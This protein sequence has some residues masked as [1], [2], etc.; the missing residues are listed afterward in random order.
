MKRLLTICSVLVWVC[1]ISPASF[2]ET[3]AI[4][5]TVTDNLGNPIA[6]LTVEVEGFETE[7]EA[8]EAVT[9]ANGFYTVTGLAYGDYLVEAC[10]G[11]DTLYYV[12]ELYDNRTNF[13][14]ADAVTVEAP[15]TTSGIDF[16]LVPSGAITGTVTDELG[17][18]IEGMWVEAENYDDEDAM[19]MD[20]ETNEEGVYVITGLPPGDYRVSTD[21]SESGLSYENEY[22][23]NTTSE[24]LAG[25]VT[26]TGTQTT[27]GIDFTL[28]AGGAISG[29]VTDSEG[30]P[31]EDMVVSATPYSSDEGWN[32]ANTD[33]NGFYTITGLS[34]D[35]YRVQ[36]CSGCSDLSYADKF[37]D[38]TSDYYGATPV[39]VTVPDTTAEIDFTLALGTYVSGYVYGWDANSEEYVALEDAHLS[40]E[41]FSGGGGWS[42]DETDEEG[43][44][45]ITGLTAGEYRIRVD[46][47]PYIEQYY[48]AAI[49]WAG[50]EPLEI[51]ADIPA[52]NI[53]FELDLGGTITGTILDA[54]TNE[55]VTTGW[56]NASPTNGEPWGRGAHEIDSDGVYVISGLPAGT[57]K[58]SAS[59]EGYDEEFYEETTD[60]MMA[61]EIEVAVGQTTENVDFTLKQES[62]GTLVGKIVLSDSTPVERANVNADSMEHMKWKWAETDANGTFT[63]TG[64]TPGQW[65]IQAHPPHGE[66]YR[67]ISDSAEM[68]IDVS[69]GATETD[70]GTITLPG[71]N[72]TG[73][74]LMPDGEAAQWAPVNIETLDWSFFQHCDTD[75]DGYFGAGGLNAGTY[76]V[77][78]ELP[79]G[80]AGIVPPEPN[81]VEI[82]DPA[83]VLDMG[84]IKY[85]TAAKHIEGNVQ[86]EDESGVPNVEVNGWRRGMDGWAWT[87][88]DDNGEFSLDVATGTWEL[89]I[90][91]SPE[92]DD[93]D[94][95]YPGY[96]EVVVFADDANDETETVTFTVESAGSEVSGTV[97]GPNGETIRHGC[98]WVDIRD[99]QGRGNGVPVG[100]GGEFS[101][102]V[103][104]GTYNVW[105]GI[106]QRTYPYW[107]SPEIE[108]FTVAEGESVELNI[109]L[110]EN[111]SSI[112][113]TVTRSVGSEPV[114][115][116]FIHAWQREGGWTDTTTNDEGNYV[117]SVRPGNW[118]VAADP[119]YTSSYVSG[120][121]PRRVVV[122]DGQAVSGIDFELVE[123]DGTIE[124]VL[125]DGSGNLLT[126]IQ[127]GWAY[128]REDLFTHEPVA[129]APVENGQFSLKV[130]NGTFYVGVHLPP[131][132][133]YTMSGEEEVVVG[134][135]S[136]AEVIV[137][138]LG[139]DATI[140]GTFYTD[141]SKTTPATG[142][143]G[144]VFGMQGMGGVWQGTRISSVDGSYSLSVS[145]GE[146]NL[147]YWIM[148]DG[149]I[150]NPPP[151]NRVT[152]ESGQTAT[153]DFVL[154]SAD[155]TIAGVILD[156]NGN[157]LM[158]AWAWAH[159]EG[160]EEGSHVNGGAESMEPDGSFSISVPSGREYDV[161]AHAPESWG[162][163][164][165]DIQQVTPQSEQTVTVT[166]QFKQSDASITG[167]VYYVE[168][169]G[170]VACSGAWVDAWSDD[171]QHTGTPA[172]PEGG[173]TLNVSSG[174]TW[175]VE[176]VYHA[177]GG[178]TFYET[179]EPV[180][181]EM[182]GSSATVNLE[183]AE[184]N[185]TLPASAS[186]TFDPNVGWTRTLED[187]TR[188]EIPAGAIPSDDTVCISIT[189]L[190]ETL[191]RTATD[192][193]IGWGYAISISEDTTGNPIVDNFNT[194]VLLTFMYDE[195]DLDEE[196]LTEDDISPAYF[197]TT[198]NSW[199]R[200]E[201]FTI[202]RDANTVTVQVN[203][204]SVWALTGVPD[205]GSSGEIRSIDLTITKCIVKAGKT[206][207][208][209]SLI[210]M[211]TYN[212]TLSGLTG[213][214]SID[215]NIVSTTDDYQAYTESV[216]FSTND[217]VKGKFNYKHKVAKGESGAITLFKLD[218]N[219]KTIKLKGT[220]IDLT[221]LA[222]PVEVEITVG[223]NAISGQAAESVV[224]GS[225][226][227]IPMRLM[228]SYADTLSV[229]K[230]KAKAG[231]SRDSFVVK[232][233]IAVEE[234][235]SVDLTSEDVVLTWGS[236]T[237]TIPSGSMTVKTGKSY[238]FSK[239]T[240]PEGG[241][242]SGKIDLD[243]CKFNVALKS[244]SLDTTSG[245]VTFGISFASFDET[246][247][248]TLP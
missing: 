221:G 47:Y 71:V 30:A 77:R 78:V 231:T 247:Q 179:D 131:N 187:G 150:N 242:V 44:Y 159:S 27:S 39:I 24:Q 121:P 188:I 169:D 236:Q 34:S 160:E 217:V 243:K 174:T 9:D 11:C 6:G 19:D 25:R 117:L 41:Y 162:Y 141:A 135:D 124:G 75:E 114:S 49:D 85:Q 148:T 129:G 32:S 195:E 116:V 232:G 177:D 50:A 161:G 21:S 82:A 144:E 215:V 154:V 5:G 201:S 172:N 31:I 190:V 92:A 134:A 158:H 51:G 132:N 109:T 220:K 168:D 89:M 112:E 175:H 56:V 226:R 80:T 224:N 93:V 76:R 244:A 2:A 15:S 68:F 119:P 155:A 91:P 138:M 53:N 223:N 133:G 127:G 166:L 29:T 153:F 37:Y 42:G 20:G 185:D 233:Q 46:K 10:A 72:L 86:R 156:P 88:T 40:A 222:C 3:G 95:I 206:P 67:N 191:Q 214:S 14:L 23:D 216:D 239:V 113:G 142:L 203:H 237:F 33:A 104:E 164:Q 120:E 200:V 74:V 107:S 209:D 167:T 94:W 140:S 54:D 99:D 122:E 79:W 73:R 65:R 57:Y 115:G 110:L 136:D 248:V 103:S 218:Q 60:W 170:N 143:E 70:I 17:D 105:I 219:K 235:D 55:P 90:H 228:R 106:D 22:Y 13:E 225:K 234:V 145:A 8:G 96:P 63:I 213:A 241:V 238:K 208:Q 163:I 146:W 16:E 26:L 184:S 36:T 181:V 202:D 62:G 182:T 118:E 196:D 193:P 69:E 212:K 128:A 111:S 194:N 240:V 43:Y 186:A 147:G 165:P 4:S 38:N 173:Y 12:N 59:C 130:P 28:S 178:S 126:D 205:E 227:T 61:T 211:G 102:S 157:P 189:P 98:A 139:N 35:S 151:D 197:S 45:K 52:T 84:T 101:I 149:Y 123:A 171:G 204:F 66:E 137:T 81:I 210:L 180:D 176:A 48:P 64:I 87:R 245:T 199:T 183:V 125:H 207:G 192:Q 1:A 230:A 108:P 18:P 97:V 83:T 58:V 246:T 152:I 100:N 229:D 7:D 198:T